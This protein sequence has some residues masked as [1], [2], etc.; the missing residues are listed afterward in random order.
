MKSKRYV[1]EGTW[2]G[3]TS[4]QSRIVHREVTTD[5]KRVAWCRDNSSILYTDNTWLVLSVREAQKGEKVEP[6][7]GYGKLIGRC[8]SQNCM[9]VA[10]LKY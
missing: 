10:E 5:V 3:Y 6:Y 4:S 7:D 2:S 1:I 8:V 9:K